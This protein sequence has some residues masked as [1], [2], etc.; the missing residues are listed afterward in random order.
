[1]TGVIQKNML[2]REGYATF[3]Q[4]AMKDVEDIGPPL[5]RNASPGR[6]R[7]FKEANINTL[8]TFD[9]SFKQ[10]SFQPRTSKFLSPSQTK[11]KQNDKQVIGA[12]LKKREKV[13][14]PAFAPQKP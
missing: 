7:L 14:A 10:R 12:V 5:T 4:M 2:F 1:M 3:N 6:M 8:P 11:K 13:P 9:D